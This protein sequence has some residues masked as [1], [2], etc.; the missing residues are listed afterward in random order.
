MSK[1][2]YVKSGTAKLLREKGF[3]LDVVE[4]NG[5]DLLPIYCHAFTPE[6]K[7]VWGVYSEDFYPCPT[8]Q[9]AMRW[10]RETYGLWVVPIPCLDGGCYFKI[11]KCYGKVWKDNVY[12][13]TEYED[14]DEPEDA[15]EAAL[16]YAL[17]NLI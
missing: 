15:I 4:V 16:E 2:E 7:E 11:Y 8:Q 1:E 12:D 5:V 10:L 9:M 17:K 6:G 14:Y 3:T 13:H